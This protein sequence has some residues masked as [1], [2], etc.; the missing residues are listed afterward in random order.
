MPTPH[1][2]T[3]QDARDHARSFG[4]EAT[5]EQ[6]RYSRELDV[7]RAA[8]MLGMATSM[9]RLSVRDARAAGLSWPSIAAILGLTEEDVRARFASKVDGTI[10]VPPEA[11]PSG[12]GRARAGITDALSKR[13]RRPRTR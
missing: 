4:F 10:G 1:E 6:K 7:W 9:A 3:E 2:P 11:P 12:L 5:A 13:W 8:V